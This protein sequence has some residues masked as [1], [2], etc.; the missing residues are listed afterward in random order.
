MD[1]I[2]II[3]TATFAATSILYVWNISKLST[4]IDDI[5]K[6]LS[7]LDNN[8]ADR[9]DA[10]NV[11]ID[12]LT[13]SNTYNSREINK[14]ADVAEAARLKKQNAYLQSLADSGKYYKQ[15]IAENNKAIKDL[16][17]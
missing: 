16:M 9:F 13:I 14:L 7:A 15:Q 12:N 3:G 10:V 17:P 5:E 8:V 4:A 11:D 2:L 6:R 1:I